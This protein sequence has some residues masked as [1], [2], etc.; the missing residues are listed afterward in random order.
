MK[1]EMTQQEKETLTCALCGKISKSLRG[2]SVHKSL[3]H[4]DEM[5]APAVVRNPPAVKNE[6]VSP[7]V[8]PVQAAPAEVADQSVPVV[9]A[10]PAD[11]EGPKDPEPVVTIHAA[12][13]E[14]VNEAP[15]EI[16]PPAEPVESQLLDPKKLGITEILV[17]SLLKLKGPHFI[18]DMVGQKIIGPEIAEGILV[19][20]N[21]RW[22][23]K[24][25]QRYYLR[26]QAE[27]GNQ[28]WIIAEEDV[29]SMKNVQLISL[30]EKSIPGNYMPEVPAASE[31]EP[32]EVEEA[33]SD[34]EMQAREA[35]L[36]IVSKYIEARDAKLEAEKA[37]KELDKE[38]R[39]LILEYLETY[40]SESDE[41]KG[42]ALV[43]LGDIKVHWTFTPGESYVKKDENKILDFLKSNAYLLA[44]EPKVNWDMWE[45][46]KENGTIP[47]QFVVEVEQPAKAS[48]HR[49][50]LVE[51]L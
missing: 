50:L 24:G 34:L 42:D 37:F 51:K 47:P 49:K 40:G 7:K 38:I 30:G 9:Q 46:L 3:S 32:E 29:L 41:G 2:L 45:K 18:F 25:Q 17:G 10:T 5:A 31:V 28:Q 11:N 14:L 20:V 35:F 36:D 26:A 48:D 1:N 33:P 27:G 16:Q 19:K 43:E 13:E 39:P 23:D 8:E 44:L 22:E 4:K 6:E 12:G 21:F 15:I